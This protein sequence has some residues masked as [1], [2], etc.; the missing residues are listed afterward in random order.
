LATVFEIATIAI[1]DDH[2]LYRAGLT[3]VFKSMAEFEVIA[4]GANLHHAI[5]IAQTHKPNL[6]ILDINI[7]GQG[8][9]ATRVISQS[10]PA[11]KIVIMSA[12]DKIEYVKA[13]MECGARGY[14]QKGATAEDVFDC[15]RAV[16]KGERFIWPELAAKILTAREALPELVERPAVP[17]KPR[18]T[19]RELD[20]ANLLRDGKTNR[21]IADQLAIS[22]KTVKHHMSVIMQKLQVRNRVE[23]T[24]AILKHLPN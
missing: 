6:M 12:S 8:L 21:E 22:E 10:F 11:T 7:P 1:V 17:L 4:Q 3:A 23:A 9:E 19:D 24:L 16:R 18:F 2:P 5:A 14:L 13:A 20:V 15:L